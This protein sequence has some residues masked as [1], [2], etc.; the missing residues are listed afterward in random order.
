M[1]YKILKYKAHFIAVYSMYLPTYL[2]LYSRSQVAIKLHYTLCS[3]ASINHFE[4]KKVHYIEEQVTTPIIIEYTFPES[5]FNS[6]QK[7]LL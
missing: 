4:H 5:F 6:H 2:H 1:E 7:M 3:V